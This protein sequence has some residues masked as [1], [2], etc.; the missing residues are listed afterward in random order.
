MTELIMSYYMD[1]SPDGFL[2]RF[3]NRAFSEGARYN[4]RSQ[5]EYGMVDGDDYVHKR[6]D[7]RT[8]GRARLDDIVERFE[9]EEADS[10]SLYLD[11]IAEHEYFLLLRFYRNDSGGIVE[12]RTT[13][14]DIETKEAYQ[15]FLG[16]CKHIFEE[17][18]L[19]YGQYYKEK[20]LLPRSRD[21][22]LSASWSGVRFYSEDLAEVVGRE[23]LLS[24]PAQT[25][26][27]LSCGG[28]MLVICDDPMADCRN[29]DAVMEH[30]G[31]TPESQ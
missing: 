21:E 14:A 9:Q 7:D 16:L 10:I 3:V 19:D 1:E 18:E 2:R 27:E 30:L 15:S 12:L 22:F 17:F 13:L 20:S 25:V 6:E 5:G 8:A 26:A 23:R 4:D 29:T 11:Y 24:T 31:H 28:I